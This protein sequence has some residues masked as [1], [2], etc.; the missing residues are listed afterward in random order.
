MREEIQA[1]SSTFAKNS[2]TSPSIRKAERH[3]RFQSHR[4]LFLL[5]FSELQIPVDKDAPNPRIP[6]NRKRGRPKP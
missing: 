2:T 1:S 4:I 6:K 5:I 3:H